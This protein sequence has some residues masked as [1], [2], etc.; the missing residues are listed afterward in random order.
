VDILFG[1]ETPIAINI[2]SHHRFWDQQKVM[3]ANSLPKEAHHLV[4]L[5]TMRYLQLNILRYFSQQM[6]F[7]T[8]VPTPTFFYLETMVL[9][10][11][12]QVLPP[13]PA[14]YYHSQ[15]PASAPATCGWWKY[16]CQTCRGTHDSGLESGNT[17]RSTHDGNSPGMDR[18]V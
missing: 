6:Y 8:P 17:S 3:V 2:W 10:R 18:T 11:S 14:E 7:D 1:V 5:G 16:V 9:D 4:I 12:F 13:M 15:Q